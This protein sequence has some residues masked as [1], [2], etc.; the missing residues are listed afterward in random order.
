MQN[1]SSNSS[2]H[3]LFISCFQVSNRDKNEIF[4]AVSQRLIY[5]KPRLRLK[6]RVQWS[7]WY[8][9][10]PSHGC[11]A[12]YSLLAH[13][14]VTLPLPGGDRLLFLSLILSQGPGPGEA[15]GNRSQWLVPLHPPASQVSWEGGM[16][17]LTALQS[18]RG[19]CPCSCCGS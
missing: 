14:A 13:P 17:W 1:I 10:S 6:G 5:S 15:E 7:R 12:M 2:H 19:G 11:W 18:C 8:L 16:D 9:K 3:G 4:G